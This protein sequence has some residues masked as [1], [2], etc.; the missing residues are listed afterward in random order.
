MVRIR[1]Y[2]QPAGLLGGIVPT[3]RPAEMRIYSQRRCALITSGGRQPMTR[4]Q[5]FFILRAAARV[6][7][8]SAI[9]SYIVRGKRVKGAALYLSSAY[10]KNKI[11]LELGVLFLS[12][13]RGI[14]Y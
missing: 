3:A 13:S 5:F 4:A 1:W 12:N 11:P 7:A 9:D 14:H 6:L 10:L 2:L 8:P